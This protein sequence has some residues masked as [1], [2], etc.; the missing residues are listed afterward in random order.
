MSPS[1]NDENDINEEA[2]VDDEINDGSIITDDKDNIVVSASKRKKR[3]KKK[4]KICK[5]CNQDTIS[6]K[7]RG[8]MRY[9]NTYDQELAKEYCKEH[10]MSYSNHKCKPHW[11]GDCGYL[12]R[13]DIEIDYDKVDYDK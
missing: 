9:N 4:K 8:V 12:I 10:E 3:S 5:T 1:P 11:C 2:I 6:L 13:Y 7:K